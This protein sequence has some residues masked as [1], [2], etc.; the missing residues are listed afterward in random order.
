M[1]APGYGRSVVAFEILAQGCYG[2][3]PPGPMLLNAKMP[4]GRGAM[5]PITIP[6][7]LEL[8]RQDLVAP[9]ALGCMSDVVL[10]IKVKVASL[11][12]RR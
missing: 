9:P 5:R 7:T 11:T 6:I 8:S 4:S 2:S 3:P 1:L 12:E 10:P